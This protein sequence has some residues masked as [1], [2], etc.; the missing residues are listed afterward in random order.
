MLCC[1][2]QVLIGGKTFPSLTKDLNENLTIFFFGRRGAD[3]ETSVPNSQTERK[4]A[5]LDMPT[6]KS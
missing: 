3:P 5:V 6:E 2:A 4:L 1:V